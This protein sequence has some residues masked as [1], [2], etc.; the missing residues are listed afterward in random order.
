[1]GEK[2]TGI[3]WIGTIPEN[4]SIGRIGQL[5]SERCEKV[6]DLDYKPLSVTMKGILPQLSSAAKSDTHENR[7]LVLKGDFA[8]N[9]RSDRRGACG[10]SE[11]DG[12][13]SLINT[14][15]APR[16][17]MNPRYYNWL[18][19]TTVFADEYYRWGHGIVDDL[20]TTNW[21]D[22]KRIFIPIP[23]VDEQ[24]IIADFLDEECAE[25]D[26]LINKTLE[27]IEVYKKI[28]QAIIVD[29]IKCG[30]NKTTSGFQDSGIG[31]IGSIPNGWSVK[32]LKFCARFL[33]N[34]WSD[35]EYAREYIGLENIVSWTGKKIKTD[36]EYDRT[37]SL[38][39][40]KND[41][42][43][44]KLRPYLAKVYLAKEN[45]C[46]SGEFAVLRPNEGVCPEYLW[47]VMISRD[48]VYEID[49]STYGIK[50]PRA[51]IDFI[52][53]MYIPI[54]PEEEQVEIAKYVINKVEELD[55]LICKK[56]QLALEI[57][58]Y[59]KQLVHDYVMGKRKVVR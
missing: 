28:K 44:G 37:Q 50:M 39:Y 20:W 30:V 35:N 27:S 4:W 11:Y 6:S 42:L 3:N 48:F 52:K 54:P 59:K 9:S 47:A 8:I 5:Y 13:V 7:K 10:I 12:S 55:E 26:V 36:S 57:E 41:I 25:I 1:M 38:L 24:K 18:F 34:K 46:C 14:V 49:N 22:M 43:F 29:A 45:G 15:L 40:D 2:T 19:H 56:N 17:K 16:G 58:K 23:P 33:Q 32:K 31:W 51:N 21:K 53:N